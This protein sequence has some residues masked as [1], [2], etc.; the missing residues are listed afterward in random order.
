MIVV[1]DGDAQRQGSGHEHRA[2][3]SRR[4]NGAQGVPDARE[5]L[6]LQATRAAAKAG[7]AGRYQNAY[8]YLEAITVYA[9]ERGPSIDATDAAA[10]Q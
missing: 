10:P 5:G 1:E 7:R 2:I 4:V 6:R 9:R 3:L 8:A